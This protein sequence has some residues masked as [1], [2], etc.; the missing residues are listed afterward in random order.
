MF[1]YTSELLSWATL[2]LETRQI[3]VVYF[4]VIFKALEYILVLTTTFNIQC[5]ISMYQLTMNI[6]HFLFKEGNNHH[7]Q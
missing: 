2:S 7:H 5:V 1:H 6:Y 3:L 4:W